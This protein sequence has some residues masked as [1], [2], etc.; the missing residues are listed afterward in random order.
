MR[1]CE[2]PVDGCRHKSFTGE[3]VLMKQGHAPCHMG[4]HMRSLATLD[5]PISDWK[6]RQ[7]SDLGICARLRGRLGYVEVWGGMHAMEVWFIEKGTKMETMLCRG[8]SV[9][10]GSLRDAV[11]RGCA[12]AG[13]QQR[14]AI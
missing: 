9:R 1:S 12:M 4:A 13:I 3:C 6:V 10:D 2:C 14:M 8:W 11:E 7:Y 5:V